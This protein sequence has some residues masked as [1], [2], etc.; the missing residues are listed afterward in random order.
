MKGLEVCANS[1]SSAV[2][3]QNGGAIRVELCENM[4][5]GGTTPSFGQIKL[6]VERLILEIWPIIRP[7][8]GDFLYNDD[9]FD[10][11]KEDI[12]ICKALGCSG[13]VTGMLTSDGKIDKERCRD[14]IEV[15]YPMPVAFH[16]AFDMSRNLEEALED[17]IELG[18]VRVLTSGGVESAFN[19]IKV[20]EK[21]INQA[22]ERIEVMPG[23]GINHQNI[24]EIKE[25]TGAQTFHS[26]AR[27]K[28]ASAMLYKNETSKMGSIEDEYEY[29]QTSVDLVRKMVVILD[30]N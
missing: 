19:G 12:K 18:I 6:C 28:I 17:L 1:F 2:A 22:D 24:L 3:A 15:A 30:S 9:E 21:L 10:L 14:L 29:D 11:M 4:A 26:S 20:I 25:K 13:V 27:V 16:R 23:A 5:E 8:G 7:R